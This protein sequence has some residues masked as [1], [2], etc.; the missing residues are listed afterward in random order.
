MLGSKFAGRL[1]KSVP[2]VTN[3]IGSSNTSIIRSKPL[4][5]RCF[6]RTISSSHT[7]HRH[8]HDHNDSF[9][10]SHTTRSQLQQNHF[11][12]HVISRSY[13]S[14]TP[15]VEDFINSLIEENAVM[16]FSKSYCPFCK[17]VK[18]IFDRLDVPY[19]AHELDLVEDGDEIQ[20]ALY[21][22]NGMSTVPNVYINGE[23]VGGATDI[24]GE[25][26]DGILQERLNVKTYDYDL[27][28]IGGGSGGLACSK[29][30]AAHGVKVALA[31]F[32]TPSPSGSTWGL[33]GTCPNVGCIPKK[34]MHQAALLGEAR[35]DAEHFGWNNEG[36]SHDWSKLVSAVQD[37]VRS[38]NWGYKV[39]LRD[40]NVKYY[41]K[42]ASLI[43]MN[44][45]KL[46]DK[47]GG[48]EV[49]TARNIVV[50]TGG[51]PVYPDV[52]GVLDNAITSDDLFSLKHSPGK[53][54]VCGASYISLE[55]A[56]FLHGL[57]Y[58]VTVMV[59]SIF[60]R[61]FDQ[62]MADKVAAHMDDSGVKFLRKHNILKLEKIEEGTPGRIRATFENSDGNEVAEEFNTVLIATGR[63]PL[64]EGIGLQDTGVA[65]NPKTGFIVTN[66]YD[67]TNVDNVYA[68]GD[69]ADGK[70][71]L[72]PVAIQAGK[73]LAKRLFAGGVE[74]CDYTNVP[75]TI[76][77][78]LE[79]GNCGLSEEEAMAQHGEENIEVFHTNFT[80]LET[81]IPKRLDNVCFAKLICDLS[82][83]SKVV[84]I[85]V[86][87]PNA[88]EL[89]QGFSI[90]LKL[91][92]RKVDFDRLIGIHPTNA[93]IFT[94]MTVTKRSGGDPSVT[95]C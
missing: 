8:R 50:A 60:L 16:I 30:A 62:Q 19:K 34:L 5:W 42:Y 37:H 89:V 39:Q 91:G 58:D 31:D 65:L 21:E 66:D 63:K 93:E 79:Y 29:E 71:E 26:E 61:G 12:I 6:H 54:L 44:T 7:Q 90:A 28:V 64:T 51:R 85:H 38:L 20:S 17:R 69:V 18:A 48:E 84:G 68:I 53:T 13:S 4:S 33:G 32:I 67:Q 10:T 35:Q 88:G 77:T 76:F 56:G 43:D 94:T 73:L 80:P 55:C 27:F 74:K 1:L 9:K 75:T 92:A 47:N 25:Y 24:Q 3:Y 72:T 83:D 49:V 46:C 40:K 78:P 81:T 14:S 95:G 45:L 2:V 36:H 52:P 11:P 23:H 41:N 70:P 86:L 87:G 59:R 15:H 57:G 22:M 82:E